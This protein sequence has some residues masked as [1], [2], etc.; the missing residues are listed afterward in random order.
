MT[1]T[2][3]W[4]VVLVAGIGW[5]NARREAIMQRRRAEE[6]KASFLNVLKDYGEVCQSIFESEQPEASVTVETPPAFCLFEFYGHA[7]YFTCPCGMLMTSRWIDWSVLQGTCERCGVREMM[8]LTPYDGR[9][10]LR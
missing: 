1:I 6:F 7:N 8:R 10:D 4:L 3:I 5:I 2:L 9:S